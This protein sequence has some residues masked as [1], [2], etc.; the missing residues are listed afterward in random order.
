M[1][2]A[3][4]MDA[5][6]AL[7][8]CAMACHHCASE[9]LRERDVQK[10]ARCIA[11]DLDCAGICEYTAAV[12]ARGSD[13]AQAVRTLCAQICEACAQECGR[14][15][16]AHCQECAKACSACAEACRRS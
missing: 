2:E 6:N 15:E 13:Q 16:M 4:Q 10:M 14:H 1:I 9:C 5:I 8:R 3:S 11:L 7:Q 12:L